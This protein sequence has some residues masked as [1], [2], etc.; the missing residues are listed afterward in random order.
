VSRLGGDHFMK[1][2]L[3]PLVKPQPLFV[4]IPDGVLLPHLS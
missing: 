4:A 2:Q 3:S 1:D